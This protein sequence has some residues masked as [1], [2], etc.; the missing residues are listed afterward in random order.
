MTTPRY[1][2]VY[3]RVS[4]E[5]QGRGFSIPTQIEGC[6]KLAVPEGYEVRERQLLKPCG[7]SS[8]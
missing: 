2:A 8:S 7:Q 6:Q 3:A 4:T 1:A 5:D